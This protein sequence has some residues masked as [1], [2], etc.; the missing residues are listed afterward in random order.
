MA[1]LID[2]IVARHQVI[3]LAYRGCR[4]SANDFQNAIDGHHNNEMTELTLIL[5]IFFFAISY[6]GTGLVNVML[7]VLH[8]IITIKLLNLGKMR[9]Y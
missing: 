3:T 1:K 5:F 2:M 7:F 4:L 8:F 9:I 6:H